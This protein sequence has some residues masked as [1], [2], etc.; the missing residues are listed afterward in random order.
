MNMV[1]LKVL[2]KRVSMN[3]LTDLLGPLLSK[4]YSVFQLDPSFQQSMKQSRCTFGYK[5]IL[6]KSCH[7]LRLPGQKRVVLGLSKEALYV[8]VGQIDAKC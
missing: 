5:N 2:W 6:L 3:T 7:T 4:Q 8:S 1:P